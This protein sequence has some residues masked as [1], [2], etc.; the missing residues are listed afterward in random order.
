MVDQSQRRQRRTHHCEPE[1]R[2]VRIVTAAGELEHRVVLAHVHERELA[3]G[4]LEDDAQVILE[5]VEAD[6]GACVGAVDELLG[7]S[8]GTKVPDP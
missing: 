8:L 1:H 2:Q 5:D 3:V 7:T 4:A 6:H